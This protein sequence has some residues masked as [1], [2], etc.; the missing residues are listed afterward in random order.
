M[1]DL[2]VL[3]DAAVLID[4]ERIAWVGP[5]SEARD[6]HSAFRIPQS[7]IDVVEVAGGLFPGFVACPTPAGFGGPPPHG[8]R[9]PAAG[10]GPKTRGAPGGGGS[11]AAG[12]GRGGAAGG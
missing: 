1:A 8:P 5:R 7:A 11:P 6:L 3:Q 9:G 12:G 2:E 4:G 10:G